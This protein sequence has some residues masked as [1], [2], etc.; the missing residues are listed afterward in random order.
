MH[1]KILGLFYFPLEL[2]VIFWYIQVY[3]SDGRKCVL[4]LKG[5]VAIIILLIG[6]SLYCISSL[7]CLPSVLWFMSG[8]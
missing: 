7:H 4:H 2:S 3:A 8:M 1:H 6:L 5:K